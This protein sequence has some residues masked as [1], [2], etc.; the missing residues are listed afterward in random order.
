MNVKACQ[1]NVNVCQMNVHECETNVNTCQIDVI[2][3]F[4]KPKTRKTQ[5]SINTS[6]AFIDCISPQKGFVAQRLYSN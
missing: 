1:M 4:L 5:K 3:V 6:I 2:T